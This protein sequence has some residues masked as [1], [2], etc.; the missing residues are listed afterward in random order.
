MKY[1][2]ICNYRHHNQDEDGNC[3]YMSIKC[4]NVEWGRIRLARWDGKKWHTVIREWASYADDAGLDV[5]PED[6]KI[7]EDALNRSV[8]VKP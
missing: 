8:E 7:I 5:N 3:H 4:D 6:Q 1:K 2:F